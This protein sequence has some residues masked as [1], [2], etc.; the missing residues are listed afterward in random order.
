MAAS[1]AT[2]VVTVNNCEY[3]GNFIE[4]GDQAMSMVYSSLQGSPLQFVVPDY[5]N[6]QYSYQLPMAI[7]QVSFPI[8]A[9][10]SSLKSLFL[11]VRES[12][13]INTVSCFPYSSVTRGITDVQYRV[14]STLMPTKAVNTYPEMFAEVMKAMGS[15]SD[16]NYTPSIE[17]YT[18][19]MGAIVA[20]SA[21][22][23]TSS[24]SFYMGLDLE[25]Y[26]ASAK[27]TIFA[28]YN[29]NT[30]DIFAIMNFAAQ[31]AAMTARFDA[32]ALFDEVIV[33]EN[34]TAY[35]KF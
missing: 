24:G 34:N 12:A 17:K 29:S 31:G 21:S 23:N 13:N 1:A 16:L 14:G 25:N 6:Y 22:G 5:R 4:L 35:V 33:F 32:F 27:D 11:T 10:F 18:Y 28:G 30:D 9:K 15:M 3:I 2:A 7:T 20:N 8:P 26:C 19:T